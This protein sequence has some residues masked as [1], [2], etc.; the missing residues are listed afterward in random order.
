MKRLTV[1]PIVALCGALAAASNN[2][3]IARVQGESG[4]ERVLTETLYERV[5]RR[6][7]VPVLR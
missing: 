5:R 6:V 7:A 4:A 1:I 2:V 3:A